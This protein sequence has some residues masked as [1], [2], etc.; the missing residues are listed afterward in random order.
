MS[1]KKTIAYY[2]FDAYTDTDLSVVKELQKKYQVVWYA[3]LSPQSA[4]T[5]AFLHNFVRGSGIELHVVTFSCRRRSWVFFKMVWQ[6]MGDIKRKNPSLIYTCCIDP[7]VTFSIAVRLAG[8]PRVQGMHDVV[9]HSNFNLTATF[10]IARKLIFYTNKNFVNFSK[11]QFE[12]FRELY[13]K[14]KNFLVGMSTKDFGKA[15][16][17]PPAF[18]KRKILFFGTLHTYK[19]FD[20]LIDAYERLLLEG[21]K[22]L[23]VSF[24][25]KPANSEVQNL[26]LEKISDATKYNLG[27]G[28]VDNNDVANIFTAHHYAIFPYRD[29]TQSGPLMIAIK[30]NVPV[31]A[32]SYG[33]FSDVVT[34]GI[35]GYLYEKNS[36]DGIYSILKKISQ[37][38]FEEYVDMKKSCERLGERF[39]EAN[40]CKKYIEIF[41]SLIKQ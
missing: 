15:T 18:T 36:S 22:N 5:P 6:H 12:I 17:P 16:I 33:C 14:K 3:L 38:S 30:Y 39:S 32:P 1:L 24:Y 7:Y 34:N 37:Q 13:P 8:V 41:E 10:K 31:I 40:I 4:Y 2:N 29:A 23:E 25:G 19:G 21:I 28:F 27:L 20:L 11:N 9:S 35:D 26:L